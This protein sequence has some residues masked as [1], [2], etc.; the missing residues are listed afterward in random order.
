MVGIYPE[1]KK[2]GRWEENIRMDLQ[3]IRAN[4]KNWIDSA[5]D[6][7]FKLRLNQTHRKKANSLEVRQNC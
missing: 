1:W 2:V 7:K 6:M 4:S 5:Q 3:E